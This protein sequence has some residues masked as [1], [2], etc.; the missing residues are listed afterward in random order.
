MDQ[1]RREFFKTSMAAGSLTLFDF[2]AER[3]DL[4]QA[5]KANLAPIKKVNLAEWADENIELSSENSAEPGRWRT[6]RTPYL[7]KILECLSPTSPYQ[8]IMFAK[9]AQIGATAAGIIALLGYAAMDP[10][11]CMYVLPTIQMAEDFSKDKLQPMIE[12]CAA[13]KGKIRDPREKGSNN[14]ILGKKYPGGFIRLSGANSAASLR[15]KSIRFLTVDEVDAYDHDVQNEGSPVELAKKR[16]ATYG[17][18][19]KIF[20]PS[21]PTQENASAIW[22]LFE[23]TDQQH[24]HLPCIACSHKQH[25][26]FEQFRWIPSKPKKPEGPN[27]P[28][29]PSTVRYE[30]E[31]CGH[32]IEEIHKTWMMDAANGAEWIALNPDK[33]SDIKIGFHLNSLY[34]PYGW[35]SWEQIIEEYE[36]AELQISVEKEDTKKRTFV[37]TT[38]GKPYATS[39]QRPGWQLLYDNNREEYARNEM[40]NFIKVITAGI[41]V[42]GD[43][44]EMEIVGWGNDRR[45]W[46]LDYRVFPWAIDDPRTKEAIESVMKEVWIRPDMTELPVQMCCMDSG[47]NTSD[48]YLLVASLGL[49]KLVATKGMDKQAFHIGPPKAVNKTINGQEVNTFYHMIGSSVLKEE[50]YMLLRKTKEKEDALGPMGYCHFPEYDELYFKGITA[51]SKVTTFVNGQAKHVWHREFQANEP[52]DCRN[53]ARAALT[54]CG[55][56]SYGN[57]ALDNIFDTYRKAQT[58]KVAKRTSDFWG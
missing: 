57:E 38:L 29:G 56:D 52:L 1:N 25:L 48:V 37:N 17:K 3:R 11:P 22:A 19:R 6:D 20:Y 8:E 24:Y 43:R 34:S 30:C 14:T 12:T 23:Q 54:L 15:N 36:A 41:D 58:T 53:Y 44:I 21:T 7:R 18:K 40:N 9:G 31:E 55:Y 32:L 49:S 39:G 33:S 51:E 47:F 26:R 27:E 5:F 35:L 42:Q 16:T 10:A 46:S 45:S 50:L 28:S 2:R 4:L 13:L